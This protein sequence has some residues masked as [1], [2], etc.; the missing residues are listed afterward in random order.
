MTRPSTLVSL[1]LVSVLLGS[2]LLLRGQDQDRVDKIFDR[3]EESKG[4]S[5]WQGIRDLEDL[6]R[7]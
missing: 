7:A 6:G 3:I 1:T 4:M 2:G 5:L